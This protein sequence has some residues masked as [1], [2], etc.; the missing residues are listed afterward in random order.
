MAWIVFVVP[1][2]IAW[3]AIDLLGVALGQAQGWAGPALL[4]G[5]AAAAAASIYYFMRAHYATE[6]LV[7]RRMEDLLPVVVFV[8]LLVLAT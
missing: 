4:S 5:L 3:I 7:V 6:R 2:F 1:W 8:T